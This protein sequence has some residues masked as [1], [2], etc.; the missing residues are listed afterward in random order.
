MQDML[1]DREVGHWKYVH[2]LFMNVALTFLTRDVRPRSQHGNYVLCTW[3]KKWIATLK[4]S[5]F[6]KHKIT[7]ECRLPSTTWSG[8]PL[9]GTRYAWCSPSSQKFRRVRPAHCSPASLP[10]L[11]I[12][13]A[14]RA[15]YPEHERLVLVV[16]NHFLSC[17]NLILLC[18]KKMI[19]NRCIAL[20]VFIHW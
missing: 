2:V 8:L 11:W 10:D 18:C 16:F 15:N 5:Q 19:I 9:R 13:D 12:H 7:A 6:L 4:S 14:W 17:F 1:G 20:K 3:L